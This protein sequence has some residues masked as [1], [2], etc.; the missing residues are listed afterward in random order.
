MRKHLLLFPVLLACLYSHSQVFY[1]PASEHN[2]SARLSK[3]MPALAKK[4]ITAYKENDRQTYF[5][6]LFRLQVIAEEYSQCIASLDSIV[7]ILRNEKN[8]SQQSAGIHYRAYALTKLKPLPRSFFNDEF[9]NTLTELY[10]ALPEN[11]KPSAAY[12]FGIDIIPLGRELDE[13]VQKHAGDDSISLTDALELCRSWC[14]WTI[15]QKVLLPGRAALASIENNQFII[16]DSVLIR[17]RDGATISAIVIRNR[18]MTEPLPAVLVFNI[19][20]GPIDKLLAQRSASK[21]YVGIVANTR[22]KRLSPEETDPFEHDALDAYDIIDWISKQSWCNGKVGMYGGSYLGFAQWAAVKKGHPALKTI[23][24][25]VAAGVGI[26]YPMF[27]NIFMGYM[28]Q[29]LHFVT[30]SKQT[31]YADFSN[32]GHWTS[33]YR[34]WYT[35]GRS[36]RSLDTLEGRPHKI[37]Q[38]WLQHPSH[39]SYWQNM[40]AYKED[41]SRI[42]IPVLTIT[43]YYDGDQQGAMYYF[44]QHYLHNKN[45]N[46][47]LLIGPYDH[48]GAQG[49]PV[50][51]L[52]GYE[53]DSAAIINIT[54]ITYK[55]LDHILKDSSRPAIL[56]NRINMQVMGANKWIHMP[57]ISRI[58]NDTLTFFFSN[59]RAGNQYKL[60]MRKPVNQE[61]IR[62]EINYLYR[63][64]TTSPAYSIISDNLP[65][66]ESLLFATEPF[67]KPVIIT[68]SFIGEIKAA[69]NKKDFDYSIRVY[70]QLP[71]GKFFD[72][73][74]VIGRASYAR[75]RNKRT[76]LRPG[77]PESIPVSGSMFTCRQLQKGSRLIVLLGVNKHYNWQINYGTGKD[78]SD[79]TIEDGKVPL[80]I[81]WFNSS[82]ISFPVLK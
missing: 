42:N 31:D 61:F 66:G 55:W 28:L 46:H 27:N 13:L 82:S 30:N 80:Q 63:G 18:N 29:W 33:V 32:T 12:Y 26:D 16:E 50:T 65:I 43:G 14:S 73:S 49:S 52:H 1:F 23:V 15:Y 71:D 37:F 35:S 47:Y 56:K 25:M 17:T 6:N 54:N 21:G 10:K 57:S 40:V 70:E 64:D 9:Q 3:S 24:P 8:Q 72:L 58:S 79:E 39:D 76:L 19:Y 53:V 77:V 41:Y 4:L 74:Q 44:N 81:Q 20:T 69:L 67:D 78:V 45:A 34:R 2:D 68:G 48:G 59:I 62:Q 60:L 38:R 51:V 36:F 5:D 7:K 22:G 11:E 75:N